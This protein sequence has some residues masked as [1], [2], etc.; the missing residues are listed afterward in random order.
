MT[1]ERVVPSPENCPDPGWHETHRYCPAC[2]WTFQEP[3]RHAT[4]VLSWK[5]PNKGE[6]EEQLCA[7]HLAA[8]REALTTLGIGC[9]A[10]PAQDGEPCG[11]CGKKMPWRYYLHDATDTNDAPNRRLER[12]TH[13]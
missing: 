11:R 7:E 1:T 5:H 3:P 6:Q 9:G 12:E 10:W 2:S 13:E 8:V 4:T